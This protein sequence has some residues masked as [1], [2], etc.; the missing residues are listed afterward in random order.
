[1]QAPAESLGVMA[2]PVASGSLV[3][4]LLVAVRPVMEGW[5]AAFPWTAA[6]RRRSLLA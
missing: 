6:Q 3:G 2:A 1:M 4:S 5:C